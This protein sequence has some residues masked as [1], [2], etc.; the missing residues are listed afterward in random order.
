MPTYEDKLVSIFARYSGHQITSQTLHQ[1]QDACEKEV[2]AHLPR[3]IKDSW[4]LHLEFSESRPG[5]I[6]L[7]PRQT[8]QLS[9]A[10]LETA[11]KSEFEDRSVVGNPVA[12]FSVS[13]SNQ[14]DDNGRLAT[15][16][17]QA[18]SAPA[19]PTDH[20]TT[21]SDP[22]PPISAKSIE[23]QARELGISLPPNSSLLQPF[24]EALQA[25]MEFKD[26]AE[27]AEAALRKHR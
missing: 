6:D 7:C 27:R 3:E 12:G 16:V 1:I 2:W 22:S 26:R 11:L 10:A 20:P 24:L 23:A 13:F 8:G 21:P 18:E 14:P 5:Q 25:A 9:P 4:A 15:R 17:A 19:R